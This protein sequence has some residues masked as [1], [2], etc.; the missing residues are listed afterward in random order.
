MRIYV[1]IQELLPKMDQKCGYEN[2][3]EKTLANAVDLEKGQLCKEIL[4]GDVTKYKPDVRRGI[5]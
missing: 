2:L 4:G 3:F 5:V 1:T